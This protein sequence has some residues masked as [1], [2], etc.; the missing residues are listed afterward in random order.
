MRYQDRIISIIKKE[1]R[2]R[3][4]TQKDLAKKLKI[5]ETSM[6]RY[7]NKQRGLSLNMA[8]NIAK[9]FKLSLDEMVGLKGADKSV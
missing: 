2:D 7:L 5:T 3:N 8:V 6:S 9:Y 1:M 4:L